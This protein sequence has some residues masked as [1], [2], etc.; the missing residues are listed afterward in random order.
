MTN[1]DKELSSSVY[2]GGKEPTGNDRKKV[3]MQKGK[4]ILDKKMLI[5]N[6]GLNT[7]NGFVSILTSR[8]YY[9]TEKYIPFS[10][11][12]NK[13]ISISTRMSI[14]FYDSTKQFISS[15]ATSQTNSGIVPSNTSF[16]RCDVY[17][18]NYNEAQIEQG[19]NAT[20]YEAYIEP[21]IYIKNSNDV[22]EE[23]IK[24]DEG[25][26]YST[27]EQKIGT[28]VDGKPLYRKVISS[29]LPKVITEDVGVT[30][31]VSIDA[32]IKTGFIEAAY[33]NKDNQMMP[34]P[35]IF[36][37]G[38]IIKSYMG[39]NGTITLWSNTTYV[40]EQPVTIIVC[41]TKTTD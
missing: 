9:G 38:Q 16:M 35:F 25:E 7:D 10:Q 40:N 32:D 19:P 22:Y 4:N 14:A 18:D 1:T 30:K 29:T 3:W 21:K 15:F 23:F 39:L 31:I 36:T 12:A 27:E 34:M 11:Y 33:F 37:G 41:Y 5:R 8:N 26:I 28:W 6:R 24:K 2:I 17:K 13:Q 20:D